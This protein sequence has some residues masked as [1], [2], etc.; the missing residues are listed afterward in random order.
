LT[1]SRA[2]SWSGL[3]ALL[4][5][6]GMAMMNLERMPDALDAYQ[7]LFE[8]GKN[9]DEVV[10]GWIDS[11]E[12]SVGGAL[13]NEL[14]GLTRSERRDSFVSA[15]RALIDGYL[16]RKVAAD[17][18]IVN[19]FETFRTVPYGYELTALVLDELSTLQRAAA[20]D[21]NESLI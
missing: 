21:G 12:Q 10:L 11:G 15:T 4:E 17:A 20:G 8:L 7:M 6:I 1:A 3:P 16:S 13:H 18:R 14:G 5:H 9:S 19:D 2:P